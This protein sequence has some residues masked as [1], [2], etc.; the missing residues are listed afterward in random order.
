MPETAPVTTETAPVTTPATTPVA[1]AFLVGGDGKFIENWRDSLPDD[2][3]SE[4]TILDK[5]QDFPSA[6]KGLVNAQKMVGANKVAIPSKDAT[7]AELDAFYDAIGRPKSVK[8]YEWNTREELKDSID[9]KMLESVAERFHKKGYSQAQVD[10]AY[11][12]YQDMIIEGQAKLAQQQEQAVKDAETALKEKWGTAYDQRLHLA[13][14]MIAENAGEN[15]D[16]ILGAVGNNPIVADFLANIAKKFMEHK[17][18]MGDNLTDA[19]MTPAEADTAMKEKIAERASDSQ[20]KY[21][22]PAKYARLNKEIQELAAK[23]VG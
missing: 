16:A 21:N 1:P 20:M 12:V 5:Y 17:V 3:K 18:P 4:K 15:K 10:E 19:G 8:D 22:N 11:G 2:V 9:S 6:I 14:R 7:Q 13:N 23:A